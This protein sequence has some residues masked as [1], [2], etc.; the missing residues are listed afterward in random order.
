MILLYQMLEA[1]TN[2][3][4]Q[5]GLWLVVGGVVLVGLSIY[6]L[7]LAC[8]PQRSRSWVVRKGE[9]PFCGNALFGAT[10]IYQRIYLLDI[11]LPES[12]YLCTDCDQEKVSELLSLLEGGR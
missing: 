5:A 10:H 1:L 4:S 8:A 12:Q 7:R 11:V 2:L 6:I 9:C 3:F